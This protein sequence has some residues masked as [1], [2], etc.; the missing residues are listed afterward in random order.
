M[1]LCKYSDIY[2]FLHFIEHRNTN[3]GEAIGV[4]ELD[5]SVKIW[6]TYFFS[7]AFIEEKVLWVDK[8]RCFPG[9]LSL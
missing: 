2:M 4:V 6:H 1:V 3:F 9:S 8:L 5:A 7:T